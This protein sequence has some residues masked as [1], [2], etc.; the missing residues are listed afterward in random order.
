[1][2]GNRAAGTPATT[3]LQR[4]KVPH[5]VHEYAH[6]PA[7]HHYGAESVA[8]LGLDAGRVF[9]TLVAQL[10][11]GPDALVCA[12]VPVSGQLDLKALAQ[13]AGA[14]KAALAEA[15]LAERV[16]G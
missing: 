16:T 9:K 5:T 2:G 1:M 12:V 8:A 6:D 14:K 4:A 10:T 13:A 7:N 3:A 15:A 11:G